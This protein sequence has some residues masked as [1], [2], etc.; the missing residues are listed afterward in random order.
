MA[1]APVSTPCW[2]LLADAC[3]GRLGA[4]PHSHRALRARA[5]SF[6]YTASQDSGLC[7]SQRLLVTRLLVL[8]IRS[9]EREDEQPQPRPGMCVRASMH[10]FLLW[11]GAA[12]PHTTAQHSNSQL[13]SDSKR[14]YLAWTAV[15]LAAAAALA[16][17]LR[18]VS[19]VAAAISVST[20]SF[21]CEV[22]EVRAGHS[23]RGG[24]KEVGALPPAA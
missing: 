14:L 13:T 11:Q 4:R 16:R 1:H 19:R 2:A 22:H 23:Q 7:A 9:P 24:V 20:P 12:C 6:S 15:S 3:T 18:F 21:S 10:A 5:R 8:A 17:E